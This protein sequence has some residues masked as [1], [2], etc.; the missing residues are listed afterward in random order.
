MSRLKV[1]QSWLD[2]FKGNSIELITTISNREFF[3]RIVEGRFSTNEVS[4]GMIFK[5]IDS[6][7]SS[8]DF[9]AVREIRLAY[10]PELDENGIQFCSEEDKY[11]EWKS[12]VL[13]KKIS[14]SVDDFDND[15]TNIF[16][17]YLLEANEIQTSLF[18]FSSQ[19]VATIYFWQ[20]KLSGEI[21]YKIEVELRKYLFS[22]EESEMNLSMDCLQYNN[23][24][25]NNAIAKF[26]QEQYR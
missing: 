9:L 10:S 26:G 14:F 6:F 15:G 25:L 20:D 24:L 12:L 19:D 3:T 7:K 23:M 11:I 16:F 1:T 22:N 18:R 13:E 4:Y 2:W 17:D 5:L 8:L 21:S